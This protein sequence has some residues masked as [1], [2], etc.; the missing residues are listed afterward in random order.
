MGTYLCAPPG[1][2]EWD[3]FQPGLLQR[4]EA[5]GSNS[6][7][8]SVTCPVTDYDAPGHTPARTEDNGTAQRDVTCGMRRR[9]ERNAKSLVPGGQE[10]TGRRN[11]TGVHGGKL[12]GAD[13]GLT[14]TSPPV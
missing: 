13:D 5:H 10:D 14:S 4:R 8:H 2:S 11:L 3:H 7:P 6:A 1:S 12:L 9:S